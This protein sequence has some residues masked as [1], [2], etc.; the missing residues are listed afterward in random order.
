MIIEEK[1]KIYNLVMN[2]GNIRKHSSEKFVL[3]D[4][5]NS[6]DKINRYLLYFYRII[7]TNFPREYLDNLFHNINDLEIKY[8]SFW[9]DR[10]FKHTYLAGT[11]TPVTNTLKIRRRYL[12][13]SIYHELLHMA[14]S[15][16]SSDGVTHSG[17]S[18]QPPSGD[19]IGDGL[20]EGYTDVLNKRFFKDQFSYSCYKMEYD[21][22]LLVE[23]II[24]KDKMSKLYFQA[25]LK[26]LVIEL[27]KYGRQEDAL[28]F[29][30]SVDKVSKKQTYREKC[31][32]FQDIFEYLIKVFITKNKESKNF[33]SRLN[34]FL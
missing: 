27:S 14:S 13:D 12:R 4:H 25:D 26:G 20:T 1:E 5:F 6:E 15:Y 31:A 3:S 11:Y 23:K 2:Y 34:E 19:G 33:R 8:C 7:T 30:K 16:Y 28:E 22:A 9:K 18:I 24:G 32:L 17:F 29:I 10:F 21:I